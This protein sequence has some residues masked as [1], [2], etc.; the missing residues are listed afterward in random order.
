MAFL[1]Q[2]RAETA[3]PVYGW[4]CDFCG[5]K[6][7]SSKRE[8][9]SSWYDSMGRGIE[10]S[11]HCTYTISPLYCTKRCHAMWNKKP[12]PPEETEDD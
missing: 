12:W 11:G 6:A 8:Q 9:P 4:A 1:G 2:L 7:E 10:F 3:G 5:Q